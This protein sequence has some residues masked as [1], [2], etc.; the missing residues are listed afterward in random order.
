M[1]YLSAYQRHRRGL[2]SLHLP[3]PT[4][5]QPTPPFPKAQWFLAAYIRDVWSRMPNILAAATS[6]YGSIL[7]MDSTK[8]ILKKLQGADAGTATWLTNVGNEQGEIL[9]PVLTTS[10]SVESLKSLADGL[11]RRYVEAQQP[12]PQVL[13]TDRDCCAVRFLH[14]FSEWPNMHVHLD[15]WHFMRR[16]ALGCTTESHPLYGTFMANLSLCIFEWDE[17]DYSSALRRKLSSSLPGMDTVHFCVFFI[18]RSK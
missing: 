10:E 15:V 5:N 6:T 11:T 14:L 12:S 7:K 2:E 9:Q 4:Y 17:D 13:Y 1:D 3:T 16:I 18:C 8:K